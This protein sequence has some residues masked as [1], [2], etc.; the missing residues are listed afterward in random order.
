MLN[1]SDL[2]Y[3]PLAGDN[4]SHNLNIYFY[5]L[6]YFY[7]LLFIFHCRSQLT[8]NLC[9]T[10]PYH[11]A[12]QLFVLLPLYHSIFCL[13]LLT[14]E[15]L[16]VSFGSSWYYTALFCTLEHIPKTTPLVLPLSI[17]IVSLTHLRT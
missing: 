12:N 17:L 11:Q 8:K 14:N 7:Q 6:R 9:S 3:C 13:I 15:M 2:Y 5:I 10:H 4:N 16:V 1:Y